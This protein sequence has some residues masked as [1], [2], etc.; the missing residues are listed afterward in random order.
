MIVSIP[1]IWANSEKS[2]PTISTRRND[3]WSN[4]FKDVLFSAKDFFTSCNSWS[5]FASPATTLRT[6]SASFSRPSFVSQ[7]GDSGIKKSPT[8]KVIAG[9]ISA[10]SI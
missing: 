2:I 7:R 8:R 10:T 6:S 3:G 5:A 1:V 4:S 9:K